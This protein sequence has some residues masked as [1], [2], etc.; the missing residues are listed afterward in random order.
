VS[1]I[2]A[3]KSHLAR[4]TIDVLVEVAAPPRAEEGAGTRV[5]DLGAGN[6]TVLRSGGAT[7]LEERS[8]PCNFFGR[9]QRKEGS[10]VHGFDL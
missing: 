4:G 9:S 5:E 7:P 2:E 10:Y 3:T 8:E 1:P 6:P